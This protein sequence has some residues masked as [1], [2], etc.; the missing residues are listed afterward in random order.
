[1]REIDNRDSWGIKW[2]LMRLR[3]IGLSPSFPWINLPHQDLAHPY[4]RVAT[5]YIPPGSQDKVN[6]SDA[7][8]SYQQP[9]NSSHSMN[10][11]PSDPSFTFHTR[12]ASQIAKY[13]SSTCATLSL[14]F[15]SNELFQFPTNGLF[16]LLPMIIQLDKIGTCKGQN[17]YAYTNKTAHVRQSII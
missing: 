16:A 15:M 14:M 12:L 17:Y 10:M 1:M 2:L 11:S 3:R 5:L 7:G 6:R 13:F 8:Y 4:N 9:I